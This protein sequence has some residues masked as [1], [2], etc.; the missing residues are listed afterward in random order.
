MAGKVERRILWW[1]EHP[2]HTVAIVV[3]PNWELATV[4]AAKWWEVPWRTVAAECTLQ[5]KETLPKFVCADCRQIFYGR[6]GERTRCA[7]CEAKARDAE[8]NREAAARRFWREMRPVGGK[9]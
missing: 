2:S 9:E 7:M 4:E 8:A 6:D 5:R 1:V 3:A